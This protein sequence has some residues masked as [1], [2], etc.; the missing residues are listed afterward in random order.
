M[1]VSI[2]VPVTEN[3]FHC[4]VFKTNKVHQNIRLT[5]D[6]STVEKGYGVHFDPW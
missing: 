1:Y 4:L 3:I 5:L 6:S 2:W